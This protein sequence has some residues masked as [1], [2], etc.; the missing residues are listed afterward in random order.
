[1]RFFAQD[2]AGQG[3]LFAGAAL[4][5]RDRSTAVKQRFGQF[6]AMEHH[7]AFAEFHK[8]LSATAAKQRTWVRSNIDAIPGLCPA[9]FWKMSFGA[10]SCSHR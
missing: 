8:R 6:V 2:S 4:L 1:M 9:V 10:V 5:G 7:A 3:Q